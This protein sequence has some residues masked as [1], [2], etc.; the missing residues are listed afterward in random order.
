MIYRAIDVADFFLRL[1]EPERDG[2]MMSGLRLQKLLYYAQGWHLAF[3]REPLFT[4]E[5]QAW[6]DG[7]VVK[8]VYRALGSNMYTH[9]QPQDREPVAFDP[10]T[11]SILE[12]VWRAYGGFT[13]QALRDRTHHEAPWKNA[14]AMANPY[15]WCAQPIDPAD[16]AEFFQ[17][18]LQQD[19]KEQEYASELAYRLQPETQAELSGREYSRMAAYLA[20]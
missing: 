14:H 18:A 20:S 15:G 13:P 11:Q 12:E 2:D 17:A 10:E 1:V 4:D 6:R 9:I 19:Q 7:P 8:S 5:I 16:M 3:T